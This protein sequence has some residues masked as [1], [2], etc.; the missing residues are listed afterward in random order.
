VRYA[1]IFS[2]EPSVTGRQR[3]DDQ[4]L[5]NQIRKTYSLDDGSTQYDQPKKNV[6]RIDDSDEEMQTN[7]IKSPHRI[8]INDDDDDVDNDDDDDALASLRPQPFEF[9]D[10]ELDTKDRKLVSSLYQL[11]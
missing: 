2:V 1:Y 11:V 4:L 9:K 6:R 8:F 5:E 7:I 3:V 10:E